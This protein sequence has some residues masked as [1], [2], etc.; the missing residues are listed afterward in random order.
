MAPCLNHFNLLQLQTIS[1]VYMLITV[2][3]LSLDEECSTLFQFKQSIIMQDDAVCDARWLQKF[4]SWKPTSSSS[5]TG[6]DC[7]SW[8]GV[9]CSKED[10]YGQ[11]I[12]LDLSESFLCG[13]INSSSTLF[14]LVN[15]QR[16]NLAMNNFFESEIPPQI[17]R[18]K[19]LRTL[20]LSDSGFTGEIPSEISQLTQL[21]SLDMSGNPLKLQSHG[22]HL[23]QNLTR[24]EELHLSGVDINSSVPRFLANFSSL[25]SIRL[26]GCSLRD[27]FPVAIFELPQ[28]KILSLGSNT[29]LIG[30]FPEFRN[31][32]LLKYVDVALTSF[33]GIVPESISNLNHLLYL[34]LTGCSFS[35]PIPGSL[36]NLT[37]LTS[38][39]LAGNEFTGFVPSLVSLLELDYLELSGNKFEKG[40]FPNWIGKMTKLSKLYLTGT[41]MYG[42]IPPFL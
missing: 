4:N 12:S 33:F 32:S 17:G 16:L 22:L 15:L 36:S 19:Q 42:E 14:N 34:R 2:S 9:V 1:F 35:G 23:V 26:F 27:E 40:P 3:S 30:S 7:C 29:N 28:L 8:D 38:L 10:K 11:V 31:N 21:S 25:S 41:N 13:H 37:R 20:N 24:L 6:F 18:L 39:R 5:D